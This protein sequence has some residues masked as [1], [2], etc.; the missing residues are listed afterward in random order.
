M[1]RLGVEVGFEDA[2]A[3]LLQFRDDV[4]ARHGISA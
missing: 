1:N 4:A 3:L 2:E